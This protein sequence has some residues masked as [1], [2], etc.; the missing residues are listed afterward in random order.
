M[1]R[2]QLHFGN[3]IAAA[4]DRGHK[5]TGPCGC[6]FDKWTGV[7]DFGF[8][9]IANGMCNAGIRYSCYN[10]GMDVP[11]VPLCQRG[12][13]AVAHLLNADAFIG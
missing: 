6:I 9:C 11:G 5:G 4:L 7:R 1:D 3:E 13:A 2:N 8:V 12:T 10:I